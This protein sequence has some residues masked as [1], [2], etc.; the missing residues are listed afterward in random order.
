LSLLPGNSRH[1]DQLHALAL[2]T[3]TK[4]PSRTD[5]VGDTEWRDLVI[6]APSLH[7]GLPWDPPEGLLTVPLTARVVATW[8]PP[9]AKPRPE[10]TCS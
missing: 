8:W 10:P 9:A 7:E 5:P 1:L 4:E 3:L 6:G 2:E